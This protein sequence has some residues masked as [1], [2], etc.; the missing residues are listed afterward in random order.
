MRAEQYNH[1]EPYWSITAWKFIGS[2][3]ITKVYNILLAVL[4]EH[5]D[6]GKISIN[7]NVKKN[8]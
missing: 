6:V 2:K 3:D 7:P 8:V 5:G 4:C 1:H